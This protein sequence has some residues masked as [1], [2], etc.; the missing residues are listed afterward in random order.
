MTLGKLYGVGLGPGDHRLLTLRAVEALNSCGRV[1][2]VLGA[3]SSDSV[4]GSILDRV[5]IARSKRVELKFSMSNDKAVRAKAIAA[6]ADAIAL[7]LE[8]GVDCAFTTIGDPL[9]FST[10]SYT[11]KVLR[12]RLPELEAEAV[13]GITSFQAAAAKAVLPLVED[14]Q[15]LLLAPLHNAKGVEK[16]FASGADTLALLKAFKTKSSIAAKIRQEPSAK[17]LYASRLFLDG[18]FF[19][20][21]LSEAEAAKESYLSLFI[22]KRGE[23]SSDGE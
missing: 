20:E 13:P 18:E 3:N 22:V 23:G 12:E 11:L 17:I 21:S 7:E 2:E 14:E 8:R 4:S 16:A 1:F 9:V 19:T 15:S 6:N 10:F 5:G